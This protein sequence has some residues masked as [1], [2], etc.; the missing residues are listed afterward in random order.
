[1]RNRGSQPLCE[2]ACITVGTP[3]KTVLL[4]ALKIMVHENLF[5]DIRSVIDVNNK[6]Y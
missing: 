5:V 2:A 6:I 3:E 4:T 1:V